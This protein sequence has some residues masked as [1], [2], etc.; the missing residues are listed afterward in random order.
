MPPLCHCCSRQPSPELIRTARSLPP[1]ALQSVKRMQL[2]Q[3]ARLILRLNAAG[4]DTPVE[5]LGD[6]QHRTDQSGGHGILR[7]T[8]Q[9]LDQWSPQFDVVDR[10]ARHLLQRH[11]RAP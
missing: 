6:C 10:M 8:Q 5:A 7:L 4:L 3:A 11:I 2:L 9:G 1:V